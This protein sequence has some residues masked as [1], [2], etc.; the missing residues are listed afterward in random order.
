MTLEKPN[1]V[2]HGKNI[3]RAELWAV[4]PGIKIAEKDYKQIGTA[5]R[6]GTGS[7]G[8]E[9]WL[10]PIPVEP[11]PATEI[12]AKV[13]D[14]GGGLVGTVSLPERGANV[15]RNLLWGGM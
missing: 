9:R 10:I 5:M 8:A 1:L 14:K 15:L 4:P 13:Y 7:D 2:I 12:F 6:D 11:V 3:G